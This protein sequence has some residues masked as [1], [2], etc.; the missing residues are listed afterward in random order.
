[1]IKKLAS[2]ISISMLILMSA[3]GTSDEPDSPNG[4]HDW[5]VIETTLIRKT[6]ERIQEKYI[7]YDKTEDY[8]RRQK[9]DFESKS[10][11]TYG[12]LYSYSKRD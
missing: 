3:C 1:M 9:K 11:K 7:V 4:P 6:S 5:D 10:N 12:F 8:M 2:F